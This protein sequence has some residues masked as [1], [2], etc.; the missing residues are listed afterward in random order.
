MDTTA[1]AQ[2]VETAVTF[3]QLAGYA[4]ILLVC[5]LGFTLVGYGWPKFG[6][7]K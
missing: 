4:L 7:K 2:T 3:G 6:Q 5:F 1:V